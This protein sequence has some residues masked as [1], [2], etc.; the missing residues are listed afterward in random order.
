MCCWVSAQ[1]T[2]IVCDVIAVYRSV[3]HVTLDARLKILAY[4]YDTGLPANASVP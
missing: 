4:A 1:L 3:L 2:A